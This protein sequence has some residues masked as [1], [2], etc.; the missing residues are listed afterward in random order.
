MKRCLWVVPK[1]IFPV[2]DGARVANLALLKAIRSHFIEIDIMLFIEDDSDKLYLETYNSEFNPCNVYFLKKTSYKN[3]I[4]KLIF[5]GLNFLKSSNLPVT[6]GYFHTEKLKKEVSLVLTHRQYDLIVFDGLHP[7]TAF[8]NLIEFKNIPVVYRAHN[9]E[10]DLWSTAASKT[11]NGMIQKLLLWQGKKM[12]DLELSLISRSTKVWNIA[13]E[14]LKRFKSLLNDN[15]KKLIFLPVGL[16]FMKSEVKKEIKGD[17]TIKLLFLGKMDWA[18]N[19]DG[20]KWFLKEVWPMVNHQK[21]ELHIVGSGDA[22]WG[23]ELFKAPG[24]KF[25]GFVSDLEAVYA[26]CDFSIIPIRYGSGTRI[27]VIE[28]ISKGVPVVSTKMGVQGSGL[29]DYFQADTA[30]DWV[31]VLS[32]LDK[33]IGQKVAERAFVQLEMMYSPKLIG[34]KAFNSVKV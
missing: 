32:A 6:T 7:Y 20:L 23:T 5:L 29:T 16:E 15:D 4:K 10:G 1:G 14:D 21:F 25:F 9:V 13:Q 18:P 33:A 24:I 12:T 19:I 2:S 11:N 28:S 8:M 17:S 27:K 34:E 31:G 22:K 3:K 26:N 30:A